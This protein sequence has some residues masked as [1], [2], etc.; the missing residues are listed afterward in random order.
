VFWNKTVA[1]GFK[2]LSISEDCSEVLVFSEELLVFRDSVLGATVCSQE[3]SVDSSANDSD[4]WTPALTLV[5]D[6][7]C[8]VL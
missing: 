1:L 7:E 2:V 3:K 6:S 4:A 8:S 5:Q